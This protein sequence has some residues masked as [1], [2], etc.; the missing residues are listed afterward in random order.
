[1]P[2]LTAPR[3]SSTFPR[4]RGAAAA[5]LTFARERRG[6]RSAAARPLRLALLSDTHIPADP[7][8]GYRGFSPVDNLAK[9]VPQVL[10]RRPMARW[11]AAI[12]HA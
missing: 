12:W 6:A 8:D 1:M 11:S 9:V 2:L 3:D 7:A 10:P 5:S 4:H